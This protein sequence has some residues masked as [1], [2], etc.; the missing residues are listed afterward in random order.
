MKKQKTQIQMKN[1]K[2]KAPRINKQKMNRTKMEIKNRTIL[3]TNQIM[4]KTKTI[5]KMI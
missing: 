1:P 2:M 4:Q 3:K 5:A